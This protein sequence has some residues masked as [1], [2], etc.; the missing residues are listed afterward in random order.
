LIADR[1]RWRASWI[2][3]IREF[4]DSEQQRRLWL[5]QNNRNP[6]WS[7]VEITCSYWDGIL[8]GE[9]YSWVIADGLVTDKEAEIVSPLDKLIER[10]EAPA[11]N[12]YDHEAILNDPAWNV[13][14]DTAKQVLQQLAAAL[15]SP[16]ERKLLLGLG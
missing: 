1:Q 13:I 3:S 5:D 9:G 7:F 12:D 16:S 2:S 6:H 11:R 10:Y 14:T 15:E 4:A 8:H